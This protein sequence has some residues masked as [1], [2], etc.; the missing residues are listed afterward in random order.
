MFTVN[1]AMDYGG[2]CGCID[3][4]FVLPAFRR[5]GGGGALIG[6]IVAESRQRGCLAMQVEVGASN[7]AAR[8]LYEKYGLLPA[9]DDRIT[10]RGRIS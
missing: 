9:P 8:M 1:F 4:L 2:L 5:R 6:A 3:D 10:V 7:V